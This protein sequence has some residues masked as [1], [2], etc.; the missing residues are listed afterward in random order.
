[1][2]AS[3]S[4]GFSGAI[5]QGFTEARPHFPSGG[6]LFWPNNDSCRDLVPA[7]C[8]CCQGVDFLHAE[9]CDPVRP[10]LWQPGTPHSHMVFGAP[11]NSAIPSYTDHMDF[12]GG[13]GGKESA[14]N[15]GDPG[16]IPGLGRSPGGGH[17]N[18]LQYSCLENL[19]NRNL[20]GYSPWGHKESDMT[21]RLTR[22][23][24]L[25]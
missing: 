20:V 24:R 13:S 3:T 2:P 25:S 15:A 11:L 17:G 23:D 14:C 1:M 6:F 5:L 8:S 4:P 21:E 16:S 10:Q 12:P 22:H 9:R 19:K 7:G 18:P